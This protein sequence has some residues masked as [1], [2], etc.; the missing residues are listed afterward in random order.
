MASKNGKK[1]T[2][3]LPVPMK[4]W[5]KDHWSTFA[6]LETIA[7]ES[8]GKGMPDL[9]RMRCDIDRHP[10][11]AV[12]SP[13]GGRAGMKKYPTRL[14]DGKQRRDHDDWDCVDDME[15]AGL[16]EIHGTGIHPIVKLTREGE[17]MAAK[18]RAHKGSGGHFATFDP[19]K[20]A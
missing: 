17:K 20:A 12:A 15:A 8:G 11:L 5:A 7:V 9:R 1:H 6:Y 2:W 3:N 19:G 14:K 18:L 13:M 10:G 16:I 4:S